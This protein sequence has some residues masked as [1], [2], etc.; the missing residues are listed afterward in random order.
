MVVLHDAAGRV[1]GLQRTAQE[2]PPLAVLDTA[3]VM[4]DPHLRA[5]NF[6]K[7]QTVAGAGTHGAA[8]VLARRRTRPADRTGLDSGPAGCPGRLRRRHRSPML[9]AARCRKARSAA[10][11]AAVRTAAEMLGISHAQRENQE[12]AEIAPPGEAGDVG[13]TGRREGRRQRVGGIL[14]FYYRSAA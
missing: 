11:L 3:E 7:T 12:G 14:N 9:V 1:G 2:E 8:A 10:A 4:A 6:F 13:S 5:R